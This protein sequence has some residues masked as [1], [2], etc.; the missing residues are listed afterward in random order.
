MHRDPQLALLSGAA[1]AI[2]ILASCAVW[3]GAGWGDG[4]T[5]AVMAAVFCCFFAAMDDPAPAIVNFGVFSLLALPLAA[6]YMFAVLPAID[7]FAMLAL[8]M[9]PP[10][11]FLGTYIT[12]P[13]RAGS[14]LAAILGFC[15]ALAL[16]ETFNADF[17]SF[18]N[19]NLGQ[20]VGLFAAVFVTASLRS[21][22]AEASVRRL[23]S[24]T[25]K[26]L[27]RLARAPTTP[28]PAAF[29]A[30]LVDRIGMITPRLAGDQAD[31]TAERALRDLRV[32]MNLVAI[33]G[34]RAGLSG[35][36][37]STLDALMTKVA[38]HFA[39]L[40]ADGPAAANPGLLA[41]VDAA[42]RVA[43]DSRPGGD[44]RGVTGLV[45]LRRGLFPTAPA[46]ARKA[47]P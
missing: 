46:F 23:L 10:L 33:K 47:A 36:G 19:V 38:E 3:I 37:R 2:A 6:F 25:W 34:L 45:G 32:G 1:A 41:Q 20:F 42:L 24:R 8:T 35:S 21:M 43:I 16:Q 15:N 9:A 14:A 12:D 39:E 26:S 22:S 17:A 30:E 28:E 5:A 4:A 31:A 40:S 27:A 11:L 18:L 13:R 29:A 44:G 7:G